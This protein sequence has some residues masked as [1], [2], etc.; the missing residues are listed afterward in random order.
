M[1]DKK[2]KNFAT[3]SEEERS[4]F[5]ATAGCFP[6]EMKYAD[7]LLCL[8]ENLASHLHDY[9][10]GLTPVLQMYWACYRGYLISSQLMFQA[11]IP[12]AY[13]ILSRSAEAVGVA[14][15]L[16][17]YP[18]KIDGWIKKD[19]KTS[20]TFI[21]MLKP[22]FPEDDKVV[23]PEVFEIWDM[24]TEHGRHPNFA[25][26]IFFSDF[27]RMKTE[28]KVDFN[29]CDFDDE[30]NPRRC[31][32]YQIYAYLRFLSVFREIFKK[33]LV[34]EWVKEF[35]QVENEYGA[36]KETLRGVFQSG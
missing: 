15:K 2:K 23:Y 30:V 18:D 7:K 1:D 32:N 10:K 11:H 6:E 4:N 25:S 35:E 20:Q 5:M 19:R 13:T 12:E 21:K 31:V 33:H 14:R 9:P 24:T 28:N 26:T 36:Y 29:Y 27:G 3:I 34:K 17:Q 16:S 22:L 8:Y